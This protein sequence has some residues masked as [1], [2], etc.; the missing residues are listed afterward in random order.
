MDADKATLD[1]ARAKLAEA[2]AALAT[3][4]LSTGRD[5]TIH[6][7]QATL[8]A[9]RASLAAAQWKLD[10]KIVAAPVDALVFDTLYRA[11]EYV[12]A[13]QP[14]TSLLSAAN[15]RVRFFV[16]GT[17]LPHIAAGDKVIVHETGSSDS[18]PAHVT[19]I[20]PNVE[21]SPPVL[22]NR[23][24]REKLVYM[25]EATPDATPERVPPGQPGDVVVGKP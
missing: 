13:G 11:G 23:D 22:Y 21:Y 10:Q 12:N 1:Q 9:S 4:K 7:A 20:S 14:V 8:T 3:G 5:D 16:P 2:D 18:I 6:A 24:N 17:D 25:I 15:I 19:Y